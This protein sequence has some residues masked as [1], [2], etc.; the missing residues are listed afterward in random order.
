MP[1]GAVY[2][3]RPSQWGNPFWITRSSDYHGLAGSW[4]VLDASGALH[5]P[6]DDT[7]TSARQKAVDLF[8]AGLGTPDG[9]SEEVVRAELGGRDL[10]C[11]CPLDEPCHADVLLAVANRL[12]SEDVDGPVAE[13]PPA[14]PAPPAASRRRLARSTKDRPAG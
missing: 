6:D 5:H 14:P 4:F 7:E 12:A 13:Q 10:V 9:L 2:V 8:A 1:A 3:G 11:W